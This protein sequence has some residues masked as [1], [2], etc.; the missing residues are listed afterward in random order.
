M[1]DLIAQA[2]PKAPHIDYKEL[3]PLIA[4]VAGSVVVLMVGLLRSRFVRV[5]ARAAAHGGHAPD[6]PSA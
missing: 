6:A 4:L 5:S 1:L 3:S 2:A